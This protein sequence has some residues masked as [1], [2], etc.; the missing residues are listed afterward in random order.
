MGDKE[1]ASAWTRALLGLPAAELHLCGDPSAKSLV[2]RICKE[3]DEEFETRDYERMT[4]LEMDSESIETYADVRPGDCIVT[5]SRPK[6][7]EIKQVRAL[8]SFDP[9]RKV[10]SF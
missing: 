9:I 2:R 5:F 10:S 6:I 3:M 1:R 8:P 4:P 7:Y